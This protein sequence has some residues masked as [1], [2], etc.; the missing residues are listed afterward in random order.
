MVVLAV[1]PPEQLRDDRR[2]DRRAA[3]ADA[4]H[5]AG[6]LRDVGDAVLE[7]VARALRRRA[8]QL[9]RRAELDVLGEPSTPVPG[10]RSRISIAARIP[11][12]VWVGGM[13]MSTTATSG[14]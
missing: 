12:S 7:Q 9:H 2:V 5:R 11:S 14:S 3:G 6:E 4:L 13:R 10:C 8:E 1:D